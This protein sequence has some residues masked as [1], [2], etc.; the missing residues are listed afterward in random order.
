MSCNK[1]QPHILVLPE[2]D[3]NRQVA[4]GFLMHES[5]VVRNIQVLPE[6][7]GWIEV[8][9]HFNID[10]V[11]G[12]DRYQDRLMVLLI[13]FDHHPERLNYAKNMV[14]ERFAER[15]FVLGALSEPEDLRAEGLGT[16][17]KIGSD[18]AQD[19]RDQTNTIWGHD[20]LRHNV[21]ELARLN[22]H[23]RPIL[24]PSN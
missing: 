21:S 17:E 12:M 10:H 14:P 9:N 6:V 3:A 15:V 18:M 20:L 5:L 4:N 23:V 1:F 24:F 16:Y 19:C 13:D 2:D 22:A 8:L 7:G 11:A